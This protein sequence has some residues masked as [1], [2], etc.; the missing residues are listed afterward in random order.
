M[1]EE[2]YEHLNGRKGA[3]LSYNSVQSEG[4]GD[5]S[6]LK[7]SLVCWAHSHS[8]TLVLCLGQPVGA[9]HCKASLSYLC[10]P[11]CNE[12]VMLRV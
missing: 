7:D 12:C 3:Y 9:L 8:H 10:K 1:K 2:G 11:V 6:S 5:S 4:F